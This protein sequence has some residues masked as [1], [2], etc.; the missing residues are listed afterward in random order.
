MLRQLL[1]Y[2]LKKIIVAEKFFFV[3]TMFL[4]NDPWC[5]TV[6]THLFLQS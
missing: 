1:V 6:E 2:F 4:C 3:K 5:L